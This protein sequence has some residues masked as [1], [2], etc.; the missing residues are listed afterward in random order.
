MNQN[1]FLLLLA[2]LGQIFVSTPINFND[3]SENSNKG[4]KTWEKHVIRSMNSITLSDNKDKVHKV[5]VN[6]NLIL[7]Y[8]NSQIKKI[9]F[10]N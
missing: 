2:N 9:F 1:L 4:D 3:L 8:C 6:S 5:T 7:D 10:Y